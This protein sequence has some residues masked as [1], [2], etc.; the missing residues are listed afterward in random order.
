MRHRYDQG[1]D[2]P[3]GCSYYN[4]LLACIGCDKAGEVRPVFDV[5]RR[6]VIHT[7]LLIIYINFEVGKI[8]L[9]MRICSEL[10]IGLLSHPFAK[11]L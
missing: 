2:A 11:F 6:V 10:L 4:A 5:V 7:T 8:T 9:I 3:L 1:T